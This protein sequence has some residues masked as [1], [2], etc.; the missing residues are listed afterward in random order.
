LINW[1]NYDEKAEKYLKSFKDNSN[2]LF[3]KLTMRDSNFSVDDIKMLSDPESKALL[4]KIHNSSL[5]KK[6]IENLISRAEMLGSVSALLDY[7]DDLVREKQ[8]MEWLLKVGTEVEKA[9]LDALTNESLKGDLNH[10]G[11]GSFDFSILNPTNGKTFYIELKSFSNGSQRPFRFAPSQAKKA[12][13]SNGDFAICLIERPDQ[14]IISTNYIKEN[15]KS[16]V[17]SSG[18]LKT[19]FEDY[20]TYKGIVDRNDG[21]DSK[22]R[23]VLLEKERIEV[24]KQT[25]FSNSIDFNSIIEIIKRKIS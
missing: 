10:I 23:L 20:L 22:L 2:E 5:S 16:I 24:P 9:F 14:G 8:S 1:A 17:D 7:A 12:I 15:T 3:F 21:Y 19:G 18:L 11:S 25:L 4:H 13:N 6:D